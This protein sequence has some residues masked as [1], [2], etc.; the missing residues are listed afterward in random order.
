MVYLKAGEIHCMGAPSLVT[1]VLGSC[2]SVT[3]YSSR[4]GIG[5]ICHALLPA[6]PNMQ[7]CAAAPCRE[8]FVYVD[9]SIR[10]MVKLFD[11]AGANRSDIEVKCFGG[12]DMFSRLIE[13]P[14]IVSVGQQNIE[15]AKTCLKR[16][17]FV[18]TSQDT[19]GMRGRKLFFNTHTG[20]VMLKR[21]ARADLPQSSTAT[22]M[23]AGGF[24]HG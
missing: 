20:E 8:G 23:R 6:C 24:G 1:T 16:E 14:G 17:G 12:S 18:I 9:C 4:L 3:M 13:K 5:A 21:L 22:G 19:G 2:V 7:T 10:Q 11:K 15:S